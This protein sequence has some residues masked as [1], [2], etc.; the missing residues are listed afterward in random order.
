MAVHATLLVALG[1]WVMGSS[2]EALRPNLEA[3]MAASVDQLELTPAA[4]SFS[5]ADVEAAPV[6]FVSA[7][8]DPAELIPK[9]DALLTPDLAIGDPLAGLDL[10][11]LGESTSGSGDGAGRPGNGRSASFFGSTAYGKSFVFVL[12][13]SGSMGD[14]YRYAAASAELRSSINQLNDEQ[15]FSVILF[16]SGPRAMFDT[17]LDKLEM[18]P[19]AEDQKTRLSDWLKR[20]RP[21]GG[22]DPRQALL[23]AIALKP[24]AIFLLSDG[25]FRGA[26]STSPQFRGLATAQVSAQTIELVSRVNRDG[27]PIHT[28]AFVDPIGQTTMQQLAEMTGGSYRFV[29]GAEVFGAAMGANR[30]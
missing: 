3:S 15:W 11:G 28:I 12:D 27:V 19:G 29:S 5:L 8:S 9:P 21:A 18:L 25:E 10:F 13:V 4:E 16:S 7:A 6:E 17:P 26:P 23:S 22:T 24:D 1:L 14:D 2:G 20:I 30:R